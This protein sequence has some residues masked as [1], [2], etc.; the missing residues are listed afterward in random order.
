MPLGTLCD[1]F[2]FTL[3]LD[4]NVKQELLEQLDVEQR[5]RRLLD[6]LGPQLPAVPAAE[7]ERRFPPD[8]S[9]N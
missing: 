6:Y 4:I 9:A 1:I 5:V 8:F 2:S 7:T 3:T